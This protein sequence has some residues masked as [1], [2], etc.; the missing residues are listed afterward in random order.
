MNVSPFNLLQH[1]ETF[2]N[3][4][5]RFGI[6]VRERHQFMQRIIRRITRN[7]DRIDC[8]VVRSTDT[9]RL[10][11]LICIDFCRTF[12]F[13]YYFSI[14]NGNYLSFFVIATN[15]EACSEI[16]YSFEGSEFIENAKV[17]NNITYLITK[18][19]EFFSFKTTWN[20]HCLLNSMRISL[21]T[22]SS[23]Y[24]CE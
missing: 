21:H 13:R 5:L 24:I 19:S 3:K 17:N 9:F 20:S 18:L 4:L 7:R 16:S 1:V 11:S 6:R 8:W 22:V 23:P 2:H 15:M 10:I 12:L 14:P